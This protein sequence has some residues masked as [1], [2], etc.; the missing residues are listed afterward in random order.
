MTLF[1]FV[2]CAANDADILFFA[3]PMTLMIVVLCAADDAV[4]ICSLRGR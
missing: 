3:Q 4:H 1:I 2:L